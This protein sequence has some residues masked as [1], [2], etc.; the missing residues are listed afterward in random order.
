MS[1]RI[2]RVKSATRDGFSLIEVV[3]ALG[4]I[5]FALVAILG[6][7]PAGLAANRT[8]ISDTR[9]AQLAN[10]ITATIDAQSAAF[11]SVN[12]YG[13][14]LNLAS[15]GASDTKTLFAGYPSPNQP[16][17]TSGANPN[18]IYTIELRFD[19]D[20]PLNSAIPPTKLG[21]GKLNQLQIR[22]KGKSNTS[23]FAEFFYLARKKS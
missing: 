23:D 11:S 20:P 1:I 5:S 19:N 18:S 2:R 6:V 4:V 10:A 7:F 12:C 8:S 16:E 22:I 17:I 3:L 9:A 13:V 14:T 15:F 21:P